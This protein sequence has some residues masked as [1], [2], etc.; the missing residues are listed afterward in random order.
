MIPS[1]P[2]TGQ[3]APDLDFSQF[4]GKVD[5]FNLL[6]EI[7]YRHDQLYSNRFVATIITYFRHRISIQPTCQINWTDPEFIVVEAIFFLTSRDTF[8]KYYQR[9]GRVF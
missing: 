9:T 4:P 1:S 3:T 2:P 8:R 5:A 6:I 7:H